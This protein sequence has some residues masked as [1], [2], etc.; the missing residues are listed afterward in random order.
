MAAQEGRLQVACQLLQPASLDMPH[1]LRVLCLF[2]GDT[3]PPGVDS[4]PLRVRG[5][6]TDTRSLGASP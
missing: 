2:T 3:F 4:P 6:T 1:T 5:I